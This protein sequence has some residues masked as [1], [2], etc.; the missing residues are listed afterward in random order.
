MTDALQALL[1][2]MLSLV[3]C[4]VVPT[5]FMKMLV[6]SLERGRSVLNFRGREVFPGLGIVWIIWAGC[7][8]I[9]GVG[10]AALGTQS[11]MMMLTL[12]GPLALV[13][14]ALGLIDD[15]YGTSADRGFRGHF[16]A[17]GHGRVTTGML[18]LIGIG[19]ASLVV[20][21]ILGQ[22]ALWGVGASILGR[23]VGTLLAAAAIAFTANLVNLTDLR[24]GRALKVYLILV[25]LGSALVLR[26]VFV[27]FEL[28]SS[29][30]SLAVIFTGSLYLALIGP[31]L[32]VW[33]FDLGER[34][35]LGDAGAN[36]MGAVAG[37][38]IVIAMPMWTLIIYAIVLLGLNLAA[39]RV[40]F[41]VVIERTRVLRWFDILG[42]LP[43]DAS[44][45][46]N[47]ESSAGSP[48]DVGDSRYHLEEDHETREV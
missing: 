36:A 12:L 11:V 4:V 39:E 28:G 1:V 22:I 35:M 27:G 23:V 44:G 3:G 26:A 29:D 34:G 9:T 8:I 30:A 40:S 43:E 18:K 24:P 14:A 38:L 25:T 6:P 32:A 7:A 19:A 21:A 45:A 13:A 15:A 5:L 20:A 48:S 10:S 31:V 41:S 37:A 42:R 46:H 47:A 17:L 2:P 16:R 33:R